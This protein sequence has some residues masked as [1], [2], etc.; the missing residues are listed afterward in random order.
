MVAMTQLYTPRPWAPLMTDHIVEHK[1]CAVWAPMGSGK[2][3]TTLTA[4]ESLDVMSGD[5]YPALVLGPLRVARK[6]WREEVAKWA[7]TKGI[8]VNLVVGDAKERQQGLAPGAELYCMNYENVDWLVKRWG[9][10]KPK[11]RTTVADESRKLKAY[12]AR[13]GGSMTKALSQIAWL[14]QMERFIELGGTPATKGLKDLWGQ[15]W[16]LD[17]GSRLGRTFKAF[18]NRW[19][20][21]KRVQDAIN[22]HKTHIESVTEQGADK[23]IHDLVKDICLSVN[24][25]DYIDIKEPIFTRVPVTLPPDARRLYNKMER[26]F[27][28]QIEN[29][30]IEAFNAG[31]KSMKLLQLSNGAAY[32]DPDVPNDEDPGA[33]KFF[34]VH[35]EKIAALQ[36]VIE[37]TDG[38]IIVAYN[39]KSDAIRLERTIP[40]SRVLK[41]EQDEDDFKAGRIPVLL[42][43]P[44]SAGHGID[45]FQHVCNTIAF[46]GCNWDL[47]L[48]LQVIERIGPTR[49]MQAGLDRPVFV[50]DI[51]AED[52]IDEVVL[53]RHESKR[54]VMEL[55][56]EATNR[57][58]HRP[59]SRDTVTA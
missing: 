56:L 36:S 27:F 47:E 26:D 12:R 58:L 30:D 8:K 40:G 43:H 13:Q 25:S 16:F 51:I 39:F 5:V 17:A 33:R 4:L 41:S 10:V 38:P 9:D 57:R 54:S 11:F 52:T 21:Y 50:Y 22:A 32:A 28:I 1:R 6:V 20:A 23:E 53:R 14:P 46:F 48:R 42:V 35:D 45:G 37:E 59:V 3:S 49:Q 44:K 24:L 31:V 19:F 15:L 2:S 18:E 55:L 34:N 29:H 7:H